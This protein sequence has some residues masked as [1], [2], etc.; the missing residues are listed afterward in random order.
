MNKNIVSLMCVILAVMMLV[1]SCGNSGNTVTTTGVTTASSTTA[2]STTQASTTTNATTTTVNT[3]VGPTVTPYDGTLTDAELRDKI[4]GGWIGQMAGVA[5]FAKSEFGWAGRMMTQ[6]RL[7][8]LYQEWNDGIVSINDAFDQDDTYVEIP[9]MDAMKENGAFCDIKYMAEKFKA[10]EFALWHANKAGR[11]NLRAGLE[12]PESGHF[13]YNQHCDDIDW[14]IECDFLGM[15]YPGFVNASAV[16][17]YEI[18]HIM[19]YGDGVYGGV[20]V[21]AMHSAAFTADS[22]TEIVN[23]GLSV[24]P[25]NT[26]F[27]EAMNVVVN[28]YEAG[29]TWQ[30][31]WQKLE[32]KYG[33][34]DKCPEMSTKAYNIDAKLN[35]AYIL[36]GLLWGEGDFEQTMVISGMCG[37][38]SDCNPSSA[39]SILGN[40][41]GAS[42]IP[43]RWKTG[44]DYNRD[45]SATKYNLNEVVDLNFDLMKQ[46]LQN[47][48]ATYA[49]GVWTLKKDTAYSQVEWEQ[50]TD[51]FDAGL[52]ASNKGGGV[53]T[54]K[55]VTNGPDPIK[56]V[57]MDMGDG[58]VYNCIVA[59]YAYPETGVYTVKYTVISESGVKV[60]KE[61]KV[62]VESLTNIQATPICE[63]VNSNGGG[64]NA[65]FDGY[66]PYVSD[67][68]NKNVQC[69]TWDGQKRDSIYA[70]LTFKETIT[71]NGVDFV[72]GI[73]FRDGGW[74]VSQPDV[75]VLIDGNWVK[76]ETQISRV[77]PTGNTQ[78]AHGNNYDIYTFT[79]APVACD[80]V[81]LKGKPGGSSSFISI[82]EITPLILGGDSEDKVVFDNAGEAIITVGTT[83][84]T[85]GGNKD[86]SVI[87][88][89]KE[90]ANGGTQYDTYKGARPGI[91]EYVGYIYK[92]S[93]TVTT[94]IYQEGA[95]STDGGWFKNGT[96]KIE[97]L[98]DGQWVEAASDVASVY[99]N[100][101]DKATFGAAYEKYTFTLSTPTACNGVR[102]IGTAGGTGGW[103]GIGE[104]T[105]K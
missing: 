65:I 20:F 100:G 77:Y 13:L 73:N 16:R 37:Q 56:S 28:S 54:F 40:F 31:C 9:F 76:V 35:A 45:F 78:A 4:L 91:T 68:T 87:A 24:I 84:P 61:R 79:F 93:V 102:L 1:C 81:R 12:A 32:N 101:D 69:D 75:E 66:I 34:V 64:L 33:T 44:L 63:V 71:I 46:V 3:V 97:V 60:E 30:Q 14:Q 70:G 47:N 85:G 7:I 38:D 53:V 59:R 27:K 89:G 29:D 18:G 80:G 8:K 58:N 23:A 51:D 92:E 6:E 48:G 39:A 62:T 50:W 96:L 22:V 99:P 67:G 104:L 55:L 52:I 10:S 105:V 42:Q 57:T 103:V 19:N 86:I 26:T 17:S 83:A 49:D 82:G 43:D 72:E 95:H 11:D 74:F 98:V 88:D 36:V 41:Y 5:F 21:T 25:D 90:A 15:M 94:V 2:S